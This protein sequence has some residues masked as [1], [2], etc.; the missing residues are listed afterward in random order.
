MT[1]Q[2]MLWSLGDVGILSG[3]DEEI[4]EREV[5][6][7]T[8]DSRAVVPGSLFVAVPGVTVDGRRFAA[9]AIAAG[10]VVAVGEGDRPSDV[11]AGRWV[12]VES[13]RFAISKC[14]SAFYGYPSQTLDVY[15]VTGTNGKT[16]VATLLHEVLASLDGKSGLISTV[17][18]DYGDG[19]REEA[20]H[21]TPDPLTLF[22]MIARMRD[23]GCRSI[24][25][26]ASSHALD[27]RRTDG[28]L[29]TVAAF[30]NLTRD[31]LDYHGDMESYFLAKRHLFELLVLNADG[32]AVVNI[33][34]EWGRKLVAW[35]E[36]YG[37]PRV[38]YGL[39]PAADVRAAHI[40][41]GLDGMRF[42]VITKRGGSAPLRTPL[43]GTHNVQNLLC[44]VAMAGIIGHPLRDVTRALG[45]CRPVCGRLE[46]VPRAGSRAAWFV[47]YAHTP[48]ALERVLKALRPETKGRLFAVFGCGGD[49]DRGK[50]PQMGRIAAEFADRVFLTSDNPRSE[51]P[52]SILEEI[53]AGVPEALRGKVTEEV[54]RREAI[55]LAAR[56]AGEGDIVLVAGKGH[57]KGQ[58]FAD[59]TVPFDDHEEIRGE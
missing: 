53:S 27:Q 24:C 4:L 59:R 20:E 11:P 30:T 26:E 23:A 29:F 44:V 40:E 32:M 22:G 46:R 17:A 13:A 34:D 49:R 43:F 2:D 9:S 45:A 42:D 10:A 7:V 21:T 14:A 35:L 47:D 52:E 54:D 1:V 25:M 16:T 33:D 55:R 50:R 37:V 31:H 28:M 51:R 57:E 58:I 56:E 5:V 48:D 3:L 12:R 18:V 36:E 41:R 15:A 19:E 38:T 39:D 8:D 6:N